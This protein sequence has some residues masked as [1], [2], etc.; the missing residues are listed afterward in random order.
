MGNL[1]KLKKVW[2]NLESVYAASGMESKG[3]FL[4]KYLGYKG[5]VSGLPKLLT[6]LQKSCEF[7]DDHEPL[8]EYRED[9]EKLTCILNNADKLL[10]SGVDVD[11]VDLDC[12]GDLVF[13]TEEQQDIVPP[14]VVADDNT[15]SI[16]NAMSLGFA[17]RYF[18]VKRGKHME[19]PVIE[20][21]AAMITAVRDYSTICKYLAERVEEGDATFFEKALF[22]YLIKNNLKT[23]KYPL[24]IIFLDGS[25]FEDVSGDMCLAS[26]GEVL[27]VDYELNRTMRVK[28]R[29]TY[30][31][32]QVVL[33]TYKLYRVRNK[34][35]FGR[36]YT[37]IGFKTGVADE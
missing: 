35:L 11:A 22:R 34:S 7:N 10:Q 14:S 27:N 6:M 17:K 21:G 36:V 29:F 31:G 30:K 37:I 12:I 28:D 24:N 16:I 3:D 18:D 5:E 8:E 32:Q 15:L 13:E 23:K 20:N 1:D 4:R 9:Y 25:K 33:G 19:L 2:L 26:T